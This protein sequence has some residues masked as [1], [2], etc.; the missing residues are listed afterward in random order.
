MYIW[1]HL[2]E[3]QN[4]TLFFYLQNDHLREQIQRQAAADDE[5]MSAIDSRVDE[6][7]VSFVVVVVYILVKRQ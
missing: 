3:K 2:V 4:K 6:W 7:K 1:L 5:V